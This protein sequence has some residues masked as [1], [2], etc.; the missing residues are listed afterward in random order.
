MERMATLC[1]A[2]IS[3]VPLAMAYRGMTVPGRAVRFVLTGPA[4]GAWTVPLAPQPQV[5]EPEATIVTGAV[6]FCLVAIRRLRPD[7]LD[8]AIE[9]DRELSDLVLTSLDALA[10]D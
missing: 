5:A 4:G 8:A 9:G 7:Q 6:D 2:L 10:R 3:A 1:T